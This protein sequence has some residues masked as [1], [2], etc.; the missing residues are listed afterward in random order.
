MDDNS[1]KNQLQNVK[2]RSKRI[3]GFCGL[4]LIICIVLA[5]YLFID[6]SRSVSD[7]GLG[8]A[9]AAFVLIPI[10]IVMIIMLGKQSRKRVEIDKQL[11][12]MTCAQKDTVLVSDKTKSGDANSAK[13]ISFL[14]N[15]KRA[16]VIWKIICSIASS[17][18][19][20]RN[21]VSANRRY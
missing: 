3:S 10:A 11:S 16:G 8:G 21:S 7:S 12:D 19:S 4:V 17:Y 20:A 13:I 5:I 15:E 6:D 2:A 9:I 18:I 14:K 1:I